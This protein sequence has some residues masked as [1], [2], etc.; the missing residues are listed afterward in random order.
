MLDVR[1]LLPDTGNNLEGRR[2]GLCNGLEHV[3]DPVLP[4]SGITHVL[5]VLIVVRLVASN[6]T[7]QV[8]HG[9]VEQPG[10]GKVEDIQNAADSP[11]SVWKGVDAFELVVDERH[12]DQRIKVAETVIVDKPFQ[13]GH[14]GD[15]LA[16]ILRRHKDDL[17]GLLV[18]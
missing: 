8:Q 3:D 12:L 6:E 9:D 11:V 13:R 1:H 7:R 5:Q 14:V 17:F 10:A 2:R 18:L 16:R 4:V 15:D